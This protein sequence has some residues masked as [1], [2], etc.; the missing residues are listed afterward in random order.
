MSEEWSF[1]GK[2]PNPGDHPR[3]YRTNYAEGGDDMQSSPGDWVVSK[4]DLYQGSEDAEYQA[5]AVCTCHY[6]P[7]PLS[8]Q[9]W[10]DVPRGAPLGLPEV[11]RELATV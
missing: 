10:R 6:A 2:V 8:E 4:V 3:I 9:V 11:D 5:I 1:T 7:I